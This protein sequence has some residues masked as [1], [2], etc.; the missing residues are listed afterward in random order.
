MGKV[1]CGVAIGR[2]S[3]TQQEPQ[4]HQTA[5]AIQQEKYR[6]KPGLKISL[7]VFCSHQNEIEEEKRKIIIII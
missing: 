2:Q 4:Q 3:S 7:L 5:T 6:K 1:V